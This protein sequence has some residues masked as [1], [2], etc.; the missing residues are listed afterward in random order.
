MNAINPDCDNVVTP[1]SPINKMII[2][3]M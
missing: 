2:G 3:N 1:I